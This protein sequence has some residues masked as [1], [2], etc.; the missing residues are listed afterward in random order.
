M[1]VNKIFLTL[2]L[3]FFSIIS[4][5][6]TQS[7]LSPTQKTDAQIIETIIQIN[8]NEIAVSKEA[9]KRTSN[10]AVKQFAQMMIKDHSSNREAIKNLATKIK[11][12]PES[13]DN[14]KALK[15]KGEDLLKN[16]KTVPKS[17]FDKT[18]MQ[19]MVSGHQEVLAALDN[20][21]LPHAT[22]PELKQFLTATR[23]AVAHHLEAAKE[24]LG[25][26]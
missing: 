20:N 13:S 17:D 11:L 24:T 12:T 15:Q 23:A 18:Y 5:G 26:L 2:S 7:N 14:S 22:N 3:L 19:A 25:K 4:L 8:S 16:L 21:F 10:P 6:A 9:E 1:K